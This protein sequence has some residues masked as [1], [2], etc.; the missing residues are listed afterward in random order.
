MAVKLFAA[1]LSFS[2]A[3]MAFQGPGAG[4]VAVASRLKHEPRSSPGSPPR[5]ELRVDT[6]VVEVPVHVTTF[7]G[8]AV[9]NLKPEDFRV[10][11]DGVEQKIHYFSQD[12]APLSIGLLFD[13]SGSMQNKIAKSAEATAAFFKTANPRDEF[14]LIEFSEKPKLVVPFTPNTDE[15]YK[16]I[17]HLKPFGRTSLLDAIH[18]ALSQMK[19]AINPRKAIVIVSDGGDNRSRYTA[20]EIKTGMLESDVQLFAMGIFDWAALRSAK[21]LP[22]E[23]QNGPRLLDELAEETGG[24]HYPVEDLDALTSIGE[25]ISRDLR[26]EYVLGYS[27]TNPAR[28]GKFRQ[29]KL[30]LTAPEE[31]KLRADYRHGYYAPSQ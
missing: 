20:A 1:V 21:K 26:T 23:E 13:A 11:E 15:I 6:S 12:D 25:S 19:Y 10:L 9:T 29:I 7:D 30:Q 14:F 17:V 24:R 8:A 3:G 4:G 31:P 2:F 27:P 28:D 5:V 22:I 18:M 16:R